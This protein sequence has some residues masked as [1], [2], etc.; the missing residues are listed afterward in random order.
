MEEYTLKAGAASID[1]TPSLG[2][3]INGEFT[4]RYANKIADRLYAKT[5]LL[6][7]SQLTLAFVVVDICAMQKDYLD[8]IKERI[9]QET[10]IHPEHILISSTHTHSSGSVTDL[11]MGHVDM[12]YRE[13]LPQLIVASV[14]QA[15][16]LAKPAKLGFGKVDVPEHVLCRRYYMRDGYKA[17]NPITGTLDQVKTNPFGGESEIVGS[18]SAVD[19]E[20]G[21]LAVKGLDGEWISLLANYS[22]HYVGDCDRGTISADY[23]GYFSRT[24]GKLLNADESFVGIMSNGTSGEANIWDFKDPNRYPKGNHEKSEL[25]GMSIAHAVNNSLHQMIWET[26]P[27]LDVIYRDINVRSRKPSPAELVRALS[28]VADTDYEHINLDQQGYEQIYAREQ[29]LLNDY[30][31]EVSF[32][33]QAFKIGSGIIGA[34]GGEFFAE[35]GLKLKE[36]AAGKA[37]FT[38][39][40]AND[41]VGYVPPAHELEKGGYETWRC[42]T[43]RLAAECEEEI[44]GVLKQMIIDN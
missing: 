24:I 38:I 3:L 40:M 29:V 21:Y 6:K 16:S 19:P 42:R 41:Y 11:L 8:D 31:D 10:H 28:I 25:I 22:L 18:A 5:L 1:I 44:R 26:N 15:L 20:V 39:T 30:P 32:P 2:T 37:Y 36:D 43:S 33:I 34:L 4:N 35:T 7:T 13:C 12:A 27:F 23:F 9:F 14:K 17:F